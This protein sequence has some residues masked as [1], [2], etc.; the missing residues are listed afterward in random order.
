MN[1]DNKVKFD[2][3]IKEMIHNS[4]VFMAYMFREVNIVHPETG[5]TKEWEHDILKYNLMLCELD[6]KIIDILK[7]VIE[8]KEVNSEKTNENKSEVKNE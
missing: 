6:P 2:D 1:N 5:Y 8:T 3:T 4:T 7:K